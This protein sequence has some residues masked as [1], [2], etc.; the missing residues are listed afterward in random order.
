M[1]SAR[2]ADMSDDG[3]DNAAVS[4]ADADD[5]TDGHLHDEISTIVQLPPRDAGSVA[6]P[7]GALR[8]G[9]ITL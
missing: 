7:P 1:A 4:G 2:F 9:V 5:E 3:D 8:G 6:S